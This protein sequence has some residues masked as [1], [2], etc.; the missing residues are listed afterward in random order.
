MQS[1]R[2]KNNKS[3]ASIGIV[4]IN[5]TTYEILRIHRAIWILD[6]AGEAFAN[7]I[8]RFKNKEALLSRYPNA[9]FE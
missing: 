9:R 5:G 6:R 2:I 4:V 8:A 7:T 1:A 3:E